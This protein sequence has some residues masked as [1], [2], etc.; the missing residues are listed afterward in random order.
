[1]ETREI[2]KAIKEYNDENHLYVCS[3]G[4]T[5]EEVFN[6]LPNNQTLFLDC[7]GSTAGVGIGVAKGCP[8]A[9][10]FSLETDGSFMY[11]LS[12]LHSIKSL[13]NS[14]QNYVLFILNNDV[15]ESAGGVPS[16]QVPLDWSLLG[17]AWGVQISIINTLEELADY[18]KS[19]HSDFSGP[20]ISVLNIHNAAPSSCEKNIDGIES[21]YLFK[22]YINNHIN[23]GIIKPCVKN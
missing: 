5:A 6:L 21:R 3:L 19:V 16:R 11:S 18:L 1:M 2:V 8:S 7:L 12:V 22:R 23:K 9:K 4:R 17:K 10:V 14:L 13:A 15:L 20:Y